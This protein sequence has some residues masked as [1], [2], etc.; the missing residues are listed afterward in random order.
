MAHIPFVDTHFHLHDMRHPELRYSWLEP[1]AVHPRLGNIGTIKSLHYRIEDYLAETRFSN[2]SKAVHVQAALGT[3]NPVNETR[4]LQSC[5]DRCGYP[6][7]IVG[8]CHLQQRDAAK[9]LEEHLQYPNM[10]GIR[11]FGYDHHLTDPSWQAGW[12]L[13]KRHNLVSCLDARYTSFDDLVALAAK[14]PTIPICIDHC[15]I[16]ES[17]TKEYFRAWSQAL[18][19]LAKAPNVYMK[20]SGLGM[21]DHNWTIESL[22]PWILRCI[23]AFGTA[24]VVFATNWPVDRM[25]SSYPDLINAY[26]AIIA[27]F[28]ATEQLA[29]FSTNAEKLFRI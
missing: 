5:A 25:Y 27:D 7:G 14:E 24:R 29:M 23:D 1:D 4:W 19:R 15:G 13:L 26:A 21:C 3:V 8:E 2:V 11:D 16:P 17:R 28:A 6:Q 18:K 9:I 12:K 22:R 10:R 20:I